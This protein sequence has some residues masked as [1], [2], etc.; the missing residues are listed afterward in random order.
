MV[1][2][3]HLIYLRCQHFSTLTNDTQRT[4]FS[5]RL[6]SYTKNTSPLVGSF[7]IHLFY[8]NCTYIY[9]SIYIKKKSSNVTRLT[10]I[11]PTL[12]TKPSPL[13][14]IYLRCFPSFSHKIICIIIKVVGMLL[15]PLPQSCFDNSRKMQR[16]W[17]AVR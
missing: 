4:S 5:N 12:L 16:K 6:D 11:D 15:I 7:I 9:I 1:V 13:V 10:I 8:Q 3:S 14:C 17:H 2:I